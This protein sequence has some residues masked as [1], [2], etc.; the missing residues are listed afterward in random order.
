[1][2]ILLDIL[3]QYKILTLWYYISN[4][5]IILSV[6]V[7]IHEF[8]H[9]IVAKM[10]GVKVES[11]SIGFGKELIGFNDKSGTRWKISIIPMGGYVK[12][13]GDIDPASSPD[14]DKLDKLTPEEEEVTFFK[15]NLWQKSAIV[16]AGPIAN[17]ILAIAILTTFYLN[18]GRPFYEPIIGGIMEDM[19]ADIAGLELGDKIIEIDGKEI[20]DFFRYSIIN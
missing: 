4:F 10:C 18:Y 5:V 7:F 16:V 2:D 17:Y 13:F 11:F 1:M 3:F 14:F 9:Y 12:M 8:G 15:K 19:P 20:S 6:I